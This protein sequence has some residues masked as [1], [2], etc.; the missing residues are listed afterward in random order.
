MRYWRKKAD[1]RQRGRGGQTAETEGGTEEMEVCSVVIFLTCS[2]QGQHITCSL[3]RKT[4]SQL[5]R[6]K[7]YREKLDA[8][9]RTLP[10]RSRGFGLYRIWKWTQKWLNSPLKVNFSFGRCWGLINWVCFL[11]SCLQLP[12]LSEKRRRRWAASEGRLRI[13]SDCLLVFACTWGTFCRAA[14]HSALTLHLIIL[15]PIWPL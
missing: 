12:G 11:P 5:I 4:P 8:G 14:A 7:E 10:W 9:A 15:C 6:A 2:N 13:K 1:Y 3:L